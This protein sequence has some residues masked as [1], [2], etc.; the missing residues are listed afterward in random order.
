MTAEI[1]ES[2]LEQGTDEYKNLYT[3]KM[4]FIQDS[5]ARVSASNMVMMRA[6]DIERELNGDGEG[7]DTFNLAGFNFELGVWEKCPC[8]GSPEIQQKSREGK[9]YLG[10]KKCGVLLNPGV[11]RLMK[12]PR[13]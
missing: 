11:I 6:R 13:K 5:E 7:P 2:A 3:K 10:C 1:Y 4:K 8:C 12:K 9:D